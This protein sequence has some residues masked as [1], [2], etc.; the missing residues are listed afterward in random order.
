MSLGVE[1]RRV[2]AEE[3]NPH[4]IPGGCPKILWSTGETLSE[5]R[6]DQATR[7]YAKKPSNNRGQIHAM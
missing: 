4:D 7:I 6:R 2:K 1:S 3:E 5:G